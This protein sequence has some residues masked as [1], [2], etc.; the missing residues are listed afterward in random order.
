ML[1]IKLNFLCNEEL[2]REIRARGDVSQSIRT[3]LERY[4]GFLEAI[5]AELRQRLTTEEILDLIDGVG[6]DTLAEDDQLAVD[7]ALERYTLACATGQTVDPAR[8][9]D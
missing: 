8:I 6:Y 1:T 4:F 7:D 9:L 5:R 3:A 2:E